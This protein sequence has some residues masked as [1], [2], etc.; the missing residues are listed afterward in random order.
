MTSELDTTPLTVAANRSEMR[1]FMGPRRRWNVWAGLLVLY[2]VATAAVAALVFAVLIVAALVVEAWGEP[3]RD[4]GVLLSVGM[5]ACLVAAVVGWVAHAK[6]GDR[7]E[8]FRLQRFAAANGFDFAPE[9]KDPDLPGLIFQRGTLRRSSARLR[10][11]GPRPLEVAN[12]SAWIAKGRAGESLSWSYFALTLD[13]PMPH[14]VLDAHANGRLPGT[15]SLPGM[16]E[17]SSG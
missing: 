4:H 9:V 11:F 15:S 17:I 12:Y 14:V 1:E 10:R 7:E 13:R 16:S 5:A 6:Q 2:A 3:I 8:L